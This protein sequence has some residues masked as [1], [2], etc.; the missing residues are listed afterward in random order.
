M[1]DYSLMTKFPLAQAILDPGFN[2]RKIDMEAL[3]DLMSGPDAKLALTAERALSQLQTLAVEQAI[4][5]FCS[6]APPLRGRLCR[7]VGRVSLKNPEEAW[8]QFLQQAL[9]DTDP[10]TQRNAI[11]ALG[12]LPLPWIEEALIARWQEEQRVEHQ[13]SLAAALGKVGGPKALTLLQEKQTSDDELRRIID[14]AV[15]KIQRTQI[16]DIPS[17]IDGSKTP[18]YPLNARLHCRSGIASILKLELPSDLEPRVLRDDI[19]EVTLQ[20]PLNQ[21]L[22]ARTWLSAGFPLPP[23]TMNN[24][25]DLAEEIAELLTSPKAREIFST[26]TEGQ[27]RYRLQW[28]KGGHRRALTWRCAQAVLRRA[29]DLINDPTQSLWEVSIRQRDD[30]LE[31]ELWPRGLAD[32]RFDYRSRDIPAAS[33]PT[34]AAALAHVAG[35]R[36]DDRVWDPFV[37]SGSELIERALLGPYQQLYGSDVDP[38]ALEAARANLT[39]AGVARWELSKGDARAFQPEDP[40]SLIITNPPMGRRVLK[41]DQILALLMDIIGRASIV[42]CPGGRMVWISPLAQE[43]ARLARKNGF[44]VTLQQR[45]DMGGFSA[46]IQVFVKPA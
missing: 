12:K 15:L 27:V 43:S 19:V 16:R 11:I 29:P 22:Q 17:R 14:Q 38:N 28:A 6:A 4:K 13:R 21:L 20:G 26:W 5:L 23:K 1:Y 37:G 36:P 10:K 24:P 33:H 7:L 31:L 39:R 25:E 2:P 40:L 35:V 32:Q 9:D 8:A 30:K 41:R 3:F 34:L 42:L 44:Q 18:P 45:V 46:E